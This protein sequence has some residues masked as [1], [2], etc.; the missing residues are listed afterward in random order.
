MI[1]KKKVVII[2]NGVVD[3]LVHP[4]NESVFQKGSY[5]AQSISMSVGGD[6]LNEATMLAHEG[7]DVEWIGCLGKDEAGSY[8]LRHCQDYGIQSRMIYK[9]VDTAVNVVLIKED[10]SRH[11]LVN[12]NGSLRKLDIDD[13][14]S[15]SGDILC[16]A[17]IFVYPT[18]TDNE[19][20]SLFSY[21]KKQNMKVVA[22][23]TRCKNNET[24]LDLQ[25]SLPLIDYLIPNDT[26]AML[27]TQTHSPQEAALKLIEAGVKHV[28]IKCGKNGCFVQTK[29][30]SYWVE[31]YKVNC[32][33]TTGAG[34]SFVSGFVKGLCLDLSLKKCCQLGNRFGSKNVQYIGATTWIKGEH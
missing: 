26:E 14:P 30:E 5:S 32:V 2:G 34:D 6:A 28:I 10:G 19:L 7:I 16:F 4:C 20:F 24:V 21:A 29:D 25:R 15:F 3:I 11:F 33:D 17:S 13:I 12:Q 1:C 8:L 31:G 23:M 9:E 22:D 27:L 18:F